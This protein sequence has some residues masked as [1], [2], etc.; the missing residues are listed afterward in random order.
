MRYVKHSDRVDYFIRS[1]D[2][3]DCA[4]KTTVLV[5]IRHVIVFHGINIGE[6]RGTWVSEVGLHFH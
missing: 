6:K 3:N 2:W 5:K 1:L 4:R